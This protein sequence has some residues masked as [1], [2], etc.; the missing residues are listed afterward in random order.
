MKL[1]VPH[2]RIMD[3][4][5]L[6]NSLDVLKRKLDSSSAVHQASSLQQ[7]AIDVL[8]KGVGEAFDLTNEDPRL[9]ERYDTSILMCLRQR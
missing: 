7:Q 9:I 2:H 1:K 6:S 5:S 8:M 4:L 3:Q